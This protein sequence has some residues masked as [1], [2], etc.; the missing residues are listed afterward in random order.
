MIASCEPTTVAS[1][2]S[3]V[4][5][6]ATKNPAA[7]NQERDTRKFGDRTRTGLAQLDLL[8]WRDYAE[9]KIGGGTVMTF[10]PYVLAIAAMLCAISPALA[11]AAA[12]EPAPH[13]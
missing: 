8:R 9:A 1:C 6:R 5:S 10:R 2:C 12:G 4:Q 13:H 3:G 11:P 7:S